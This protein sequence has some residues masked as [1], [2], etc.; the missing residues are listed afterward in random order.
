MWW[1]NMKLNQI[2]LK[3]NPVFGFFQLKKKYDFEKN[4]L[5]KKRTKQM[6]DENFHLIVT[7]VTVAW[8]KSSFWK[9]CKNKKRKNKIYI[10]LL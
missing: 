4:T 3:Q 6:R 10:S 1:V 7:I 9:R 2:K 5:T 8:E